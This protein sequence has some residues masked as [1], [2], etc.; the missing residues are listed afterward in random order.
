MAFML[1]NNDIDDA[2]SVN[3]LECLNCAD[4][5]SEIAEIQIIL[6]KKMRSVSKNSRIA[7]L[8][9]G[10]VLTVVTECLNGK[11]SPTVLHNPE[12]EE[13]KW[14]DPSHSSIYGLTR[15]DDAIIVA[16]VLR[17]AILNL[18]PATL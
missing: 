6:S 16:T 18:Y 14:D 12:K 8:N 11:L 13:G 9:V 7:V 17:D 1:D 2:L 3:W 10:Q 5:L 15:H 4:R